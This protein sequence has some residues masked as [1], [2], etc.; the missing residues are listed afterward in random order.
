MCLKKIDPL[1]FELIGCK[2]TDKK[3][4]KA[5]KCLAYRVNNLAQVLCLYKTVRR[6]SDSLINK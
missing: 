4:L 5:V 3:I 1:V 6:G 2:Q